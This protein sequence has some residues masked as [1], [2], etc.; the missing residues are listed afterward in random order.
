MNAIGSISS[1]IA[2][3]QQLQMNI[4]K[5]NAE[6]EQQLIEMLA[7]AARAV[8]TSQTKGISLDITI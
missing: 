2:S 4:V 3:M 1:Y 8:P 5:Q 7:E 6:V